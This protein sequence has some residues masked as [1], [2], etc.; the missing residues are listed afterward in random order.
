MAA[1]AEVAFVAEAAFVADAEAAFVAEAGV[2]AVAAVAE[3]VAA[4]IV[5]AVGQVVDSPEACPIAPHSFVC[6]R[7]KG[8][9]IGCPCTASNL[10][11]CL[12][13]G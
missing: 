1:A 4:A 10:S 9:P 3:A 13:V 5:A 12:M 7:S 8:N 6:S 2:A 11:E